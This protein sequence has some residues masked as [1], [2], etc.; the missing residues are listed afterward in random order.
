MV[1]AVELAARRRLGV[2]LNRLELELEA[3]RLRLDPATRQF[4]AETH[5]DMADG[6]F[7]QDVKAQPTAREIVEQEL[8]RR[9]R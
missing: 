7:V 9:A 3:L 2:L 4:I 5:Q 1:S 8:A 6:T